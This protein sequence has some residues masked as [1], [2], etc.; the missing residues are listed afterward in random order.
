[1]FTF[2]ARYPSGASR[3][4]G[5]I[6]LTLLVGCSSTTFFYNRLDTLV[7]W[8]VSDYVSLDRAQKAVFKA[9][10]VEL[11]DWHRREELPHY[12]ALLNAM[13]VA[14]DKPLA[15]SDIVTLYDQFLAAAERLRVAMTATA[16]DFGRE[17][18]QAQR[19]EFVASIRANQQTW[20]DERVD[21]DDDEYRELLVR[22]CS[23]GLADFLGRRNKAQRAMIARGAEGM[24]RLHEPWHAQRTRWLDGLEAAL[25]DYPD[26]WQA[27]TQRALDS[28]DRYQS[29]E[30]RSTF[31][32]NQ[33][34]SRQLVRDV[35]NSRTSRQDK[36]LRGVIA[37]Y[38]DDFSA[39]LSASYDLVEQ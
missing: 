7:G 38:R 32:H 10:L 17:L 21:M 5:A 30:Y 20:Y 14:L 4:A 12:I 28:W 36:H 19:L 11:H 1:M 24:M 9:R 22:R 16:I 15:D 33:A 2:L 18:T 34:L 25:R 6:L 39:L 27:P 26:N 8:Y 23:E 13:D 3:W 29:E 37:D 35:V 31:A